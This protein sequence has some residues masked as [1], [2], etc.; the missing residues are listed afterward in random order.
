MVDT[1]LET[2]EVDDRGVREIFFQI[3]WKVLSIDQDMTDVEA[4]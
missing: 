4:Y 3:E 2:M 1:I